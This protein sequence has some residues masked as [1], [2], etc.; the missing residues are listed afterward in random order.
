M[1]KIETVWAN[2]LYQT[3]ER[4][5]THFQQQKLAQQLSISL[6][7]V[8]HALKDIR[9]LGA[10]QVT[11]SG[12]EV[13]DAEKI[14]MHW[15]N[16]R[17]IKNDIVSQ[18]NLAP[19]PIEVEGSLPTAS[20]LGGYSAVRHRFGETPADYSAV[21]VYHP[22]PELVLDRFKTE[23]AGPT[24]LV[25]LNLDSR[26]PVDKEMTTLA[27]TF[28]DLWNLT[29]W[30]AKDFVIRV[31]QEIDGVFFP[32]S[33]L[34]FTTKAS[35][36]RQGR[37]LKSGIYRHYKG[38]KYRLI[39][40]AIHTETTEELVVYQALYGKKLLWI[41]PLKMFLETVTIGKQAKPRFQHLS[42]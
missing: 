17:S 1:K 27:H 9:R 15:A 12:G 13:V 7:T 32:N 16:R 41:R 42:S 23:P 19:S 40:V 28:V 35:L 30:M 3:L 14:L 33:N 29:D 21:Y 24:Q 34:S 2:L 36:S 26:L 22:R 6:S 20:I 18:L 5:Q 37:S 39:G 4:R 25:I 10:I 8:N 11:G 38:K 31:K